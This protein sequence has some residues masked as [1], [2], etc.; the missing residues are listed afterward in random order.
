MT[1]AR[2]PSLFSLAAPALPAF[3]L[4]SFGNWA[5][6]Y[7][8]AI[9]QETQT[10]VDLAGLFILGALSACVGGRVAVNPH[11]SWFEPVNVY[12]LVAMSPANRKSAVVSLVTQ[13]IYDF[14]RELLATYHAAWAGADIPGA[15]PPPRLV[16]DDVTPESAATLLAEN[17]GALAIISAEGDLI[18]ALSG[19][20]TAGVPN[21]NLF[22]K[23]HAG[24]ELR[25]D[26]IGR[27][28]EIVQRPALTIAIAAQPSV[29]DTLVASPAFRDRG[30]SARFL[31]C[32][33]TSMV[34]TRAFAPP[35]VP[36]RLAKRYRTAITRLLEWRMAHADG[37]PLVLGLDQGALAV[38]KELSERLE[39]EL[40]E[41][42]ALEGMAD[43][44]GKLVGAVVRIAGLLHLADAAAEKQCAPLSVISGATMRRAVAFA[45]YLTIH[46]RH[47]FRY[48]DDDPVRE[49]ARKI[50][51][52]FDH[53]QVNAATKRDLHNGLRSHF[54]RAAE[55][56]PCLALLVDEGLLHEAKTDTIG[57]PGRPSSPRYRL[58]HRQCEAATGDAAD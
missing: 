17:G 14:E 11:G 35:P 12:A 47:A 6:K 30:L 5:G 31:Y 23:G 28:T 4:A 34:G 29:V 8:A 49:G 21:L 27:P 43:W 19:R 53:R 46:A 25:V 42:G 41:F 20:Y 51:R 33:P 18:G 37:D 48:V 36:A 45:D 54:N 40:G 39:P 50:L 15:S 22:L 56:D 57:K 24:D 1:N 52:W 44:G 16:A 3:P 58:E 13:P 10:P 55:L 2:V 26:R 9:A 32:Q 38:L 7:A